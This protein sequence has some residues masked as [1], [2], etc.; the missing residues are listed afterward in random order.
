MV[1]GFGSIVV[2]VPASPG[3]VEVVV[4]GGVGVGWALASW[5]LHAATA[6]ASVTKVAPIILGRDWLP[7][8]VGCTRR[9][10]RSRRSV[11][12]H[13]DPGGT[14]SM[15]APAGGAK[16]EAETDVVYPVRVMLPVLADTEARSP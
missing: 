16:S 3:A 15:V 2:A 6:K 10:P 5:V 9:V 4:V 1:T 11:L 8:T 12:G 14:E 7:R 13:G